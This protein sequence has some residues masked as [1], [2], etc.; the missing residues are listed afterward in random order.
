MTADEVKNAVNGI[1]IKYAKL[2]T[3]DGC[4][5]T[6][7]NLENTIENLKRKV[8]GSDS[9]MTNRVLPGK[10]CLMLDDGHVLWWRNKHPTYSRK[11]LLVQGLQTEAAKD[12]W[13]KKQNQNQLCLVP[14]CG[15]PKYDK[16]KHGRV[17]ERIMFGCK[18]CKARKY[19]SRTCQKYDWKYY[20]HKN[21]L[22]LH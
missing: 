20:H 15:K 5:F 14:R 7:G 18:G 13:I 8:F 19:C 16:D 2:L 1:K 11:R 6:N 17:R 10:F 12:A 4:E 21:C 3:I 22:R 9:T